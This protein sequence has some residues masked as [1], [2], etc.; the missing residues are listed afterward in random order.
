M[1]QKS[2]D[3]IKQNFFEYLTGLGISPK[4]HKNY[5]SDLVHFSG[6]L[7]LK[8][9]SFGSYIESL[10]EAV[11]FLS[12]EIAGEYKN[13]M[14]NN[15]IPAKTI[16]RRLST[17][18][19]LSRYLLSSENLVINFMKDI[20]NISVA[21]RRKSMVSPVV[22]DFRSYLETQKVSKNTVKNYV[23]DIRQFLVWV[24][25]NHQSQVTNY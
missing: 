13:Y 12:S 4:S 19:H 22:N 10:T 8:V 11:P 2:S 1:L 21:N 24:E 17:L 16:N 23:S 6:W 15:K 25:T 20:E 3:S 14:V 7:I 18:R 9:R 5:K